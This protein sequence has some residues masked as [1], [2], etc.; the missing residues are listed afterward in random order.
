MLPHCKKSEIVY[1]SIMDL[2]KTQLTTGK[3]MLFIT[4]I[5]YCQIYFLQTPK[6]HPCMLSQLFTK[7]ITD[8][9]VAWSQLP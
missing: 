2:F 4:N 9:D 3:K 1:I 8:G 7:N 6:L 5:S